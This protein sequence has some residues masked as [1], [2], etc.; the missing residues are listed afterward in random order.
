MA[1]TVLGL[2]VRSLYRRDA[3]RGVRGGAPHISLGRVNVEEN[4]DLNI[5]Q[6]IVAVPTYVVYKQ[7][8][9]VKKVVGLQ[10]KESLLEIIK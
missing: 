5:S 6:W 7:G 8:R 2:L 10:D 4:P 1:G 9:P 3:L